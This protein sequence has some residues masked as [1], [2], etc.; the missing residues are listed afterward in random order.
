LCDLAN[1]HQLIGSRASCHHYA[2]LSVVADVLREPEEAALRDGGLA[3]SMLLQYEQRSEVERWR[4]DLRTQFNNIDVKKPIFAEAG[5][6]ARWFPGRA[7][8]IYDLSV[9]PASGY[10]HF[11]DLL[12]DQVSNKPPSGNEGVLFEAAIG[13]LLS[14]TPGFEVRGAFKEPDEQVDLL[15]QR[16]PE[17]RDILGVLHGYGLVEC[18]ATS[19]P[20]GAA[21][22]RDFGAK[23]FMH[24]ATFGLLASLKGITGEKDKITAA[25]LTRRKFFHQ[26]ITLL[27]VNLTDLREARSQIDVLG[28]ALRNDYERL[29]F[30]DLGQASKV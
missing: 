24:D 28:K 18:R 23:C 30:G 14:A 19:D 5:L 16:R 27:V 22:L 11:G 20:V 13:L 2:A 10:A 6:A 3:F 26:G 15:V 8:P 9:V 7:Q 21:E 25:H 29:A 17:P 4:S 1:L 12:I